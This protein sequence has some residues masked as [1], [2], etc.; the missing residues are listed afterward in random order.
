MRLEEAVRLWINRDFTSIPTSLIIKAYKDNPEELELLSNDEPVY[1]WPCAH[2]WMFHPE[3]SSDE[4]W[5]RDNI[6]EVE[7]CGFIV[8]D[9]EETGIL[10]G[11]DAGGYCF[12]DEHWT[13]LYKIRGLQ[14][15]E[16]ETAAAKSQAVILDRQEKE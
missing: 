13:P 1:A 9:A 16:E 10:L 14:W 8:Y 15:H 5:I 12:Y 6:D 3:H 4:E 2:G 7:E 11:I